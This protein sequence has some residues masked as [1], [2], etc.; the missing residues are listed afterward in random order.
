MVSWTR[1][2][3][4]LLF[5]GMP[6]ATSSSSSSPGDPCLAAAACDSG[7]CLG[8]TCCDPDAKVWTNCANCSYDAGFC[9]MCLPG[10]S[11]VSGAGCVAPCQHEKSGCKIDCQQDDGPASC[12]K[13]CCDFFQEAS[14]EL[15]GGFSSNPPEEP[16]CNLVLEVAGHQCEVCSSCRVVTEEAEAR[17]LRLPR[18]WRSSSGAAAAALAALGTAALLGGAVVGLRRWGAASELSRARAAEV[19]PQSKS[20]EEGEEAVPINSVEC[21]VPR[22]TSAEAAGPLQRC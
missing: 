2:L 7:H 8:G 19:W 5:H 21:P 20:K 15:H 9:S 14:A 13:S 1:C 10:Y 12:G 6:I 3:L 22:A 16:G 4:V 17:L 18:A 11:W